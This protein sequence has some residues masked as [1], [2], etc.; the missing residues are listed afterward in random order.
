MFLAEV[1]D[2][3]SGGLEDPQSEQPEQ[4]Y[5]REVVPVRR[6]PG[7]GEQRFQLPVGQPEGR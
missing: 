6:L 4:A 3:R 2:V 5:E 7:R 1:G